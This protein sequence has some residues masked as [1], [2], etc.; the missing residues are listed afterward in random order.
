MK[1][2]TVEDSN[3]NKSIK[4]SNIHSNKS[5]FNNNINIDNNS[6][7][8]FD[9]N[10]RMAKS[11]IDQ[12]KNININDMGEGLNENLINKNISSKK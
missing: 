11:Q 12:M 1:N 9:N 3:K 5:N 7:L 2:N 10:F 8:N 4:T 6:N